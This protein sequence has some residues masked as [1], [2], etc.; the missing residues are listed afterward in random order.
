MSSSKVVHHGDVLRRFGLSRNPYIDRT[1]EQSGDLD[2]VSLFIPSDLRHFRPS[3]ATFLFFGKRG[4]INPSL[5]SMIN[6]HYQ[7]VGG[8]LSVL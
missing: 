6:I 2:E 3:G 1:A 8:E 7:W 5:I 4:K